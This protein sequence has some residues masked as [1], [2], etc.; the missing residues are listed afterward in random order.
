MNVM[1]EKRGASEKK[2]RFICSMVFFFFFFHISIGI[3]SFSFIS[4]F[5]SLLAYPFGCWHVL[6]CLS[7]ISKKINR[8]SVAHSRAHGREHYFDSG[9]FNVHC[10]C[11]CC[12]FFLHTFI[13]GLVG[14]YVAYMQERNI[15]Y[16]HSL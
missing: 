10:Y 6:L 12:Y 9:I 7:F 8:E 5:R 11:C 4:L 1:A 14:S 2:M 3:S 16:K 13:N 15:Q